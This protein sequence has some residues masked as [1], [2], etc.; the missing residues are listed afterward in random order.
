[1]KLN[2]F[3]HEDYIADLNICDGLIKWFHSNKKY[4]HKGAL[5]STDGTIEVDIKKKH[6]TDISFNIEESAEVAVV[7]DYNKELQIILDR[8]LEIYHFASMVDT[9]KIVETVNIQYYKPTEG[10]RTFHS[11]RTSKAY[12]MMRYLVFQTYLNTVEDAGETEF[13]YQQYKCKAVKGKTLIWPVNWTH[14]HRGIVSPTED[15]YIITGWYSFDN[16]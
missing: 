5:G 11:E 15:K 13:F 6:S 9:F 10:Y 7:A 4:H 14:S 16:I 12:D 3:I 2:N 1:M 8:Y